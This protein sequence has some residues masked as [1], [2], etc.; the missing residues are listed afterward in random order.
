MKVVITKKQYKEAAYKFLKTFLGEL[1][2][3]K[4]DNSISVYGKNDSLE[5]YAPMTIWT[6]PQRGKGCKNDLTLYYNFSH[7]LDQFFPLTRKKIFSDVLVKYVYDKT[8]IKCDCVEYS[9]DFDRSGEKSQQYRYN[10]KKKKKTTIRENF[11]TEANL[12]NL[13]INKLG[14]DLT[15]KVDMITNT[16]DI[17]KIFLGFIGPRTVNDWLNQYG[18]MYLFTLEY[19]HILYQYQSNAWTEGHSGL[20]ISHSGNAYTDAEFLELLGIPPMGITIQDIIDTFVKEE[21]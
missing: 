10:V 1:R 18:P 16:Y 5:D 19:S 21:D 12:K 14:V 11:L 7:Q 15:G 17:P 3:E 20:L 13:L 4:N 9:Y 8:G 6:G 2:Y